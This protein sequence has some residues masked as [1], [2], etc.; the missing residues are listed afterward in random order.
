MIKFGMKPA[1]GM[2]LAGKLNA[3]WRVTY[4]NTQLFWF[5]AVGQGLVGLAMVHLSPRLL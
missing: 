3:V 2:S 5:Y 1:M 4:D